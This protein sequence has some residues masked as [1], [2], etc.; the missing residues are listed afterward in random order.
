VN[1]YL[2]TFGCKANQYDTEAVRQRLEDAGCAIV[3]AP[4]GAD[5]A[6]VN[7]CA[8]T[9]VG[10]GKMRGLVRR[11]ARRNPALRTVVMGCAAALDDG[12][13]A[14]LPGVAAVVAGADGARVA[15]ALGV[16][17]PGADGL[18]RF[19]SGSRA[20]LKIQDGCDEHCTFC[21]T[22]LA[23]GEARSRDP[24]ALARE[25]AA[26]AASHAEIVLT[27]VHIGTYGR[28]LGSNA[29]PRCAS[30]SRRSRPRSWTG[31]WSR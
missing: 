25:A 16:A 11:L 9:H 6:V 23:R 3:A 22:V 4:E 5:A 28:D 29:C 31:G 8:V 17:A 24:E 7:S 15:A 2:H 18:R 26:L 10:E 21:A 27:G 19:A 30:A 13:I 12:R 1:V 14:A 20:W